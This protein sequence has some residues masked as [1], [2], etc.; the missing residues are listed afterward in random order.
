L[1]NTKLRFFP[2]YRLTC[3]SHIG[4]SL[5]IGRS[6]AKM[7]PSL[8]SQ[9]FP[10]RPTFLPKDLPSLAGKVF[11]VTGSASGVGFELAKILCAAGAT[12]YIGGRSIARCS[13]AV[14]K[15]KAAVRAGNKGGYNKEGRVEG[16]LGSFVAD[17]ADLATVK[18]AAERFMLDET[19]LDGLIHNAGVMMP[20]TGSKDA[21]VSSGI[22]SDRRS[23]VL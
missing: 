11:I 14:D 17:L 2:V 23:A 4:V 19:R 10:P 12:V 15:V 1:S 21:Q 6:E 13:E 16:K 5:Y 8:F 7:P 9:V 18:T 22:Y 20:P 3:A